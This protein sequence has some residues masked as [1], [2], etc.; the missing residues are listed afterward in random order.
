MVLLCVGESGVIFCI[1]SH[2]WVWVGI[3]IFDSW[4]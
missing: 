4:V 1:K 3:V 2:F